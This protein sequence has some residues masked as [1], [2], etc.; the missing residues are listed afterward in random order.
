[1]EK[2]GFNTFTTFLRTSSILSPY[3]ATSTR[4]QPLHSTARTLFAQTVFPSFTSFCLIFFQ[5]A[6]V[7]NPHGWSHSMAGLPPNAGQNPRTFAL[8][9]ADHIARHLADH[10]ADYEPREPEQS[11][12]QG[13]ICRWSENV[14]YDKNSHL[15]LP[16]TKFET[17]P[18]SLEG[19]ATLLEMQVWDDVSSLRGTRL[20]SSQK[21]YRLDCSLASLRCMISA[22]SGSPP[23]IQPRPSTVSA[24][25]STTI[26]C[27][28]L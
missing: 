28:N 1:M 6:L 17:L 26:E 12:K 8:D 16:T 20:E 21:L 11:I 19:S 3:V 25:W 5:T 14:A 18:Q 9:L 2:G 4:E 10:L 23:S 24:S 22:H 15:R 13:A 7:S 27:W